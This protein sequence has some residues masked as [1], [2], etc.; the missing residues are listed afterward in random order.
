MASLQFTYT[1]VVAVVMGDVVFVTVDFN[2]V[3]AIVAISGYF[4]RQRWMWWGL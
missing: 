3:A 1:D 2:V 4:R